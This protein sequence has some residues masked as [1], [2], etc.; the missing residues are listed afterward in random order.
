MMEMFLANAIR[1]EGSSP[2]PTLIGALQDLLM[3]TDMNTFIDWF[4]CVQ[5]LVLH[6]YFSKRVCSPAFFQSDTVP[7]VQY[8]IYPIDLHNDGGNVRACCW[9][10]ISNFFRSQSCV[11]CRYK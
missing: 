11:L 4:F 6:N 8:G 1:E 5:R 3:Y 10:I 7:L 9:D 2:A